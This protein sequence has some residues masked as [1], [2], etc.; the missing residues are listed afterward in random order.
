MCIV[1]CCR[2]ATSAC[3]LHVDPHAHGASAHWAVLQY[4]NWDSAAGH[5]YLGGFYLVAPWP[6]GDK[7]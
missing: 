6:L 7:K 2:L 3:P 5:V 4:T 1:A